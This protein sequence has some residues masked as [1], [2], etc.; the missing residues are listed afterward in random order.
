ML[1]SSC[2]CGAVRFAADYVKVPKALDKVAARVGVKAIRFYQRALSKRTGR[3]CL[4]Q[5]SCSHRAAQFLTDL[6]WNAGIREVRRQIDRCG[7]SY[8]LGVS[9]FGEVTLSTSDGLR[10]EHDEISAA[11]RPRPRSVPSHIS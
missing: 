7:G 10:F 11:I 6:G 4:F 1:I 9:C 5:P 3:V 8:S 2:C